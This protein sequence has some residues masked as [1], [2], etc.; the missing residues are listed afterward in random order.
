MK[1]ILLLCIGLMLAKSAAAQNAA[2]VLSI[3]APASVAPGA[4]FTATI[5]MTNTGATAWTTEGLYNLG[6]E[7]PRDNSRWGLGRIPLPSSP[8]N[9]GEIAAFSTTFT[10]PASEG[11]YNFSWGMVQDSVE[12][13]GAIAS[14]TIKVGSPQFVPGD[15]VLMQVGDGSRA[16]ANTGTPMFLN[17]FSLSRRTNTF[18]VAIPLSGPDSIIGGLS[19]FTGMIDLTTDKRSIVV[20]GYNTNIGAMNLEVSGSPRAV[21]TVSSSGDFQLGVRTTTGGSTFRGAA[22]DGLGNFWS[23]GQAGGIQYL[24]TNSAPVQISPGG[25]GA[26]RNMIMVNGSPYF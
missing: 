21:G 24:G 7:I 13:F 23:G 6:S 19:Q 18:Q 14:K 15:L 3:D 26:I 16:I 2:A 20:A 25:A 4:T 9:P 8:I 22:S 1:K 11:V 5:T 12:W 17:N 10:A